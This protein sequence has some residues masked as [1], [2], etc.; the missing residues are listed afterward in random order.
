MDYL[1]A[2][3]TDSIF[4]WDAETSTSHAQAENGLRRRVVHNSFRSPKRRQTPFYVRYLLLIF[5]WVFPKHCFQSTPYH[6]YLSYSGFSHTC[7]RSTDY[8]ALLSDLLGTTAHIHKKRGLHNTYLICRL[9]GHIQ[10]KV[11]EYEELHC[12]TSSFRKLKMFPKNTRILKTCFTHW[13]LRLFVRE[14]DSFV[15]TRVSDRLEM[16]ERI[17]KL[18]TS[19]T[20]IQNRK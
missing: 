3:T 15:K 9:A 8:R 2:C 6:P 20:F 18:N 11:A 10:V 19:I 1:C 7:Q 16:F 12:S 14:N 4:K 5:K 17:S 13:K